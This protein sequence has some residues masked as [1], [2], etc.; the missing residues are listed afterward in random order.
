MSVET[1]TPFVMIDGFKCYA[2]DAAT[3]GK[4]YPVEEFERLYRSEEGSFWFRGRQRIIDYIV[5][6]FLRHRPATFLEIGCG[7]GFVLKGLS[8]H[9]G[10]DLDGRQNSMW[11]VCAGLK[12]AR[13]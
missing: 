7:T 1:D 5:T 10:L 13:Q 2:P 8:R 12:N 11:R 9:Q 6:R 3:V 4:D